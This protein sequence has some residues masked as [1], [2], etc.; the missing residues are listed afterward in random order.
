[1]LGRPYLKM[2]KRKL[3]K[4]IGYVQT[5]F[6]LV[7]N[8]L[9]RKCF[10]GFERF[11]KLHSTLYENVTIAIESQLNPAKMKKETKGGDFLCC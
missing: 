1:M 9:G 5:S 6:F 2:C 3:T 7:E 10:S 8:S 4:T 11:P